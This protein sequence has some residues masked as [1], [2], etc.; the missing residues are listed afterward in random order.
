MLGL[1]LA[2]RPG[3]KKIIKEDSFGAGGF[4]IRSTI[5]IVLAFLTLLVFSQATAATEQGRYN[6]AD[7]LAGVEQGKAVFDIN[8]AEAAKLK[9]YLEVIEK[10]RSDLVQQGVEP[11]IVIA[12]RGPSVRLIHS[13]TAAFSE[14]DR[15]LLKSA[16]GTLADL[17]EKGVKVE[18]CSI[19]TTLFKVDNGTLLPGIKVVGNTFVSLTGYQARGYALVPIM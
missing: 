12:F 5:R 15:Q 10:T 3:T 18:A 13:E 2:C 9:L 4:M 7:A 11:D 1:F 16:A 8:L 19:A 17:Q 14:G 6:D